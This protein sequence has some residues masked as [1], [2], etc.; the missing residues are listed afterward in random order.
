[1]E[2][3]AVS[4]KEA[5]RRLSVCERTVVN[6]INSK[7]LRSLKIGRRRV[8]RI[9]DLEDFLRR[10]HPIPITASNG[11]LNAYEVA[12]S[13]PPKSQKTKRGSGAQP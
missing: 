4:L 1:M 8:V 7:E 10:D 2:I 12:G 6:L 3:L 9:K 13:S 11:Q 5:G